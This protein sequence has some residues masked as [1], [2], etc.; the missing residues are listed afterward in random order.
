LLFPFIWS[1]IADS[2]QVYGN[3]DL[4]NEMNVA[5]PYWFSYPGYNEIFT[6]YPDTAVNSNDKI[7]NRN[8]NVL[9]FI[10]QQ[11]S[12]RNRVAVFA[13]WD[14][15]PFILNNKRNGLY[16]NADRDSL[17]F[18]TPVFNVLDEMQ[19]LTPLPVGERPD[20]MTYM[21]AKQYLKVYRPKVLYIAFDET[22]DYAHA[23]LY[24]QYLSSAHAEDHMISD[25]WNTIQSMDGY[26]DNTTLLITCDHGRGNGTDWTSHGRS[27]PL[28]DQIWMAVLGPH[29]KHLGEVKR[30][31]Q[32]YQK[33][34][35]A[36]IAAVLHFQFVADHPV[37]AP[38]SSVIK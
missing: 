14:C 30:K 18:N 8:E 23:G 9:S 7:W 33:Q 36:T 3:R 11:D 10:N 38:I 13:T 22:D 24:D 20:V 27:T 16:I 15:Y 37:A 25:L 28:S 4:G 32:V 5:N 35:A 21:I 2:G 31:E 26:K 1:V 17:K 34:L 12:Y 6:G 19:W 29:I